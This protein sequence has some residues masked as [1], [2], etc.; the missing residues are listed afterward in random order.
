MPQQPVVYEYSAGIARIRLNRPEKLNSLSAPMVA[1][2]VELLE[3]LHHD[4]QVRC[5]VLEAA[6]RAF[7]AGQ[8]LSERRAI[9]DGATM[10]LGEKLDGGL[11]R[12]VR[13]LS[14]LPQPVVCAVQ[15]VAAGAGASLAFACDIVIAANSASFVQSFA[16]LGLVPD[17]GAS[18]AL[19]RLAGRARAAG[20]VLLAEPLP[21]QQAADWGMIWNCVDDDV[22]AD[23]VTE[24]ATTLA[25][26]SATGLAL[27]KV[28]LQASYGNSLDAQLNLERDL[29]REAGFTEFYRHSIRAFF[30]PR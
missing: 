17:A 11:N 9:V 28:A 10:D 3:Q 5:V 8:D 26:R 25:T 4:P 22:L 29:Q 7:C 2:L 23:H 15:G 24:V 19:P 27:C 6:G 1:Q 21:A 13:V 12:V 14:D 18:W 30:A 20:L 16:K